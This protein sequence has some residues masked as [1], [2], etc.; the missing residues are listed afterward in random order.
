M[1][2]RLALILSVFLITS[3]S[4]TYAAW[5]VEVPP[6]SEGFEESFNASMPD[7]FEPL[8]KF[9]FNV[10]DK[11]Y[12]WVLRPAAKGYGKVVPKPVR[13]SIDNFFYNLFTPVRL[14]NELLQFKFKK[15]AKDFARFLAN[16]TIGIG[17]LFDPAAK[18]FNLPRENEDL[19]QTLGVYGIGH[20][21]YIDWPLL[22]PSSV[23]DTAGEIGDSF[24]DP[25]FYMVTTW[26][27]IAIEAVYEFNKFSL[28]PDQYDEIKQE[29]FDPYI[30]L[31]NIYFQYREEQV[32]E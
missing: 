7:P 18:W 27:Y 15:L 11:L 6:A 26:T 13:R 14:I 30:S 4:S 28:N 3:F 32:R 10:N 24:L 20:I 16:T 9:F 5:N 21:A 12:Y 31:R 22:G 1:K 25:I 19:G 23:R 2:W 17:G 29:A 8:N